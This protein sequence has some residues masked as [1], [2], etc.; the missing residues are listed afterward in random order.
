[1]TKEEAVELHAWADRVGKR[2]DAALAVATRRTLS[3]MSE[4]TFS[5]EDALI[6]A[7]IAWENLVGHGAPAEMTFRVTSALAI[8][9]EPDA[10]KRPSLR[11]ELS[12][13]YTLRSKVAHGSVVSVDDKLAE[14]RDRAIDVAIDAF[15]V[16]FHNHPSL[17]SDR[18]RGMKLILGMTSASSE[19]QATD[20][21][22]RQQG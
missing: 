10:R 11:R 6:D 2:N 19:D 21:S 16:L 8:L 20:S 4:R 22:R 1:M 14:M 3:A 12:K 15:R 5:A 13:I 9:L 17:I 18:D 7:V